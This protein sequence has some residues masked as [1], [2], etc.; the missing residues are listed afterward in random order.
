MAANRLYTHI[1]RLLLAACFTVT[2]LLAA[3]H[4]GIVKSGGLPVPGATITATQGD[5]KVVT[6]TD[7]AGFYSFPE[8][9][10]GIWTI[11]VDMLG[12]A[13][14]TRDVGVAEDAPSPMWDL[15]YETLEAITAPPPTPAP[16]ATTPAAGAAAAPA[17]AA[18]TPAAAD[19]KT[20]TPATPA[21]TTA[22]APPTTTAAAAPAKNAKNA[23]NTKN[24]KTPAT[25]AAGAPNGGRP[26]LNAALAGQ[27][28]GGFTRLGVT[29]A[30]DA[31]VAAEAAPPPDMGDAGNQSFTINGSVSSGLD[32][33]QP[34]GDWFGGGGRGGP[35]GM[36]GDMGG[37][38]PGGVPGMGGDPTQMAAGGDPAAGGAAGGRGGRGGGGAGGPGGGPGGGGP[39]GGGAPMMAGI[40]N[41]GGGGRGGA[42][43]GG[44]GGGRGGAPGG[45]GGRNPASF[46]NNRR[47]P[48]SRYNFSASTIF[49]N[50]ALNA[51]QYSL[52]GQEVNKPNAQSIRSTLTAGGPIKIPHLLT[53]NKGTFTI[54]YTLGRNRTGSTWS[55]LVPTQSELGGNFAGVVNASGQQVQLFNGATP[56]PNNQIPTSAIS[57]VALALLKYYPQPNFTGSTKYN[58]ADA[59]SGVGTSDNVNARLSY[60][61]NTK[62]QLSGG[63]QWQRSYTTQPS[64]FAV[65]TPAWHDYSTS[66]GINANASYIYHFTLR[67]IATTRYT[68]SRASALTTPY[69][70][71][72]TN[73]EGGLGIIGTDQLPLNWGPPSLGFS[74]GILGMSD[75]NAS[76]SHPQTNAL[77]ETVLWVRGAHQFQ[78]GGD[79]SRREANTLSQNNPR[80]SYSFNGSATAL[81]GI[82]TQIVNGASFSSGYDLADFLLGTPSTM[83]LNVANSLSGASAAQ[84]A[85]ASGSTLA[86]LQ[87]LENSP[88]GGDRYLRTSVYDIFVNDNWQVSPRFSLSLGLRWDYQAPTTE[89]YGRLATIDLPASFAIPQS[90]YNSLPS[91]GLAVVAG[92]TGPVTGI[93][94]SDSML[95]GQKTDLS[96][97]IGF[98]W[99]PYAKHSLVLRGG[100]GLYYIPSVYSSL[101]GQLDAQ[102]PFSTAFN[103]QNGCGANLKNAFSLPSLISLGCL[104]GNQATTTNA[105][106]TDFRV[107]YSQNWQ[108]AMSQNLLLNTVATVTYFAGK[109]T[110]LTQQYYPNSFPEASAE[111]SASTA[112]GPCA[113]GFVCPVGYRYESSN[114]NSTDEGVQF[115][116]QRRLRSGFGGNVSYSYNRAFNDTDGTAQNWLD[117]SNEHARAAGIRNDTVSF[118]LQY[119]TGVGARGGGLVNGWKGQIIRDWTIMSNITLAS[120]A[121]IN[122]ISNTDILGGTSASNVIRA[123]YTG[124]PAYINGYLNPL[125]FTNAPAGT[126]GNL[127]RDV[128]N[129]P[130]QFSISANANRTFR[131][132]DRKN[133]TFSLQSQN[134]INHPVVSSWNTSINSNQFGLP[135]GYG[136]MRSVTATMRF[137]F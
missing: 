71:N 76:F 90:V 119:S 19:T 97:R 67:V 38:G 128:L 36:G 72:L 52:T 4:H 22:P 42:G 5:K 33:P 98:A 103:I 13:K 7:D 73:L 115:Q 49:T 78:F 18:A 45:R 62:H 17:G 88:S 40:P 75:A 8:L 26:S 95:N 116:L 31:P 9:A 125:A 21:A 2:G 129:G 81:N 60:T 69:F 23:K 109:G 108:L 127:G 6:T 137:N 34:G 135:Q 122:V 53:N 3:E 15:K 51:R 56:Y 114:G 123:D 134:P 65:E 107:G 1:G 131:L 66:N 121:P 61:F 102:T 16:A 14:T 80:G 64:E 130:S 87:A 32:M 28:G 92:Q 11:S 85:T 113:P 99:K 111:R 47:D 93:K 104:T 50:S 100:Y 86:S 91:T 120:G 126:F 105:I 96:P 39:G 79:Y 124:Q 41:I 27:G 89:L 48:R 133:L 35:G 110:G 77:G 30:G 25:P 24:A 46:G 106:N 74:S 10:D 59:G 58:F 132:A 83:S 55:S 57:P 43:G 63:I 20:A 29:Q 37:M 84:L 12:F 70:A 101:V 54:N 68:Y 44:R 117:L 112:F 136:A 94:Y 82:P 118:Q